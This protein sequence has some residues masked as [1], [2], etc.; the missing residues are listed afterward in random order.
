MLGRLLENLQKRVSRVWIEL[1]DGVDDADAPAFGCRG[2]AKERDRLARLVHRDHGAHHAAIIGGSLQR[3]QAAMRAGRHLPRNGVVRID[4]KVFGVLHGGCQ[5][6]GMGEHEARHAIGQRCLADPLRPAD[7]PGM[8]N[9]PAA[10]G[11]KQRG[12]GLTMA[13]Q[14]GCLA[15]MRNGGF[16]L[17]LTRAHAEMT[18]AGVGS[19][20]SRNAVQTRPATVSGSELASIST[21]RAGSSAAIL[22]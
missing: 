9:A 15:R 16:A 10:I 1:V 13:E 12:L 14:P 6:L 5:R 20:R 11:R 3:Q 8:W 19:R 2:R 22:R 21:Q 18:D 17:G 7:Q 4:R